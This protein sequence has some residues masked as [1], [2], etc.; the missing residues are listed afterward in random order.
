VGIGVTLLEIYERAAARGISTAAAADA[1]VDE[2][3]K[4]VQRD[5]RVCRGRASHVR[6]IR[7]P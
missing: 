2:R 4:E 7:A 1:L 5:E 3:L 6:L